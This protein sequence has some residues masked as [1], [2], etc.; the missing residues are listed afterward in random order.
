VNFSNLN[1][2]SGR[3]TYFLTVEYMILNFTPKDN[4]SITSIVENRCSSP[5]Q[6]DAKQTHNTATA[7][8]TSDLELCARLYDDYS[9][10]YGLMIDI[11]DRRMKV[12]IGDFQAW[13]NFG[14]INVPVA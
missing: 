9:I 6:K 5:I 13:I 8:S 4:V 14:F 3:K 11:R 10:D 2:D 12:G 1:I 7:I